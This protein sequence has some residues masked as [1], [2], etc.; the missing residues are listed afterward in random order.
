MVY[1]NSA[2]LYGSGDILIGKILTPD[3]HP[4]WQPGLE[5]LLIKSQIKLYD[6]NIPVLAPLQSTP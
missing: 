4:L 2:C 5:T 1:D 3:L 6:N